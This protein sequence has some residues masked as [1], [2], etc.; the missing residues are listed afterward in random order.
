MKVSLLNKTTAISTVLCSYFLLALI[1]LLSYG[2]IPPQDTVATQETT[3][4]YLY[5][6]QYDEQQV[7]AH[8]KKEEIG[9]GGTI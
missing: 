2:H 4:Y 1:H 6:R 9:G 3:D 8:I 5:V 7:N